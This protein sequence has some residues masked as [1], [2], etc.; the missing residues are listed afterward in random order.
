MEIKPTFRNYSMK[1]IGLGKIK[2]KKTFFFFF[3]TKA[4][5]QDITVSPLPTSSVMQA[6]LLGTQLTQKTIYST[7]L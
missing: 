3:W 5:L 6:G 1:P 4:T 2:K 7:V